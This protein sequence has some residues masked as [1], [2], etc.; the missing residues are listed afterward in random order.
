MKVRKVMI[1]RIGKK[2]EK[3]STTRIGASSLRTAVWSDCARTQA[4]EHARARSSTK[5]S[6][7]CIAILES[8]F[9]VMVTKARTIK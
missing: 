7:V 5:A 3:R 9:K 4:R 1:F 8:A 6:V 2:F